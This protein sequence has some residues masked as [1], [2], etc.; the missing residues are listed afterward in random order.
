MNP[1]TV[2]DLNLQRE[3]TLQ[4]EEIMLKHNVDDLNAF[5]QDLIMSIFDTYI[6]KRLVELEQKI[7]SIRDTADTAEYRAEEAIQRSAK[8]VRIT[9]ESEVTTTLKENIEFIKFN[10]QKE[11]NR[12]TN[13]NKKI[14]DNL[15]DIIEPLSEIVDFLESKKS[16]NLRKP[17]D[18][19][20]QSILKLRSKI[21]ELK[22]Y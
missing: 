18:A 8:A 9:K 20:R 7:E 21:K 13:N 6:D 11:I 4:I 19:P 14:I 1:N 5:E 17:K 3:T 15:N 12:L 22:E 2:L 10:A 16:I